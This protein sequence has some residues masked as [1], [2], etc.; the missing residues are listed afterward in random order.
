MDLRRGKKLRGKKIQK[1][2]FFEITRKKE[3]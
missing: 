2:F 3:K 1:Q